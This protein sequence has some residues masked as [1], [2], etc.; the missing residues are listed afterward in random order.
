MAKQNQSSSSWKQFLR[1]KMKPIGSKVQSVEKTTLR[2]AKRFV[3]SRL[4]NVRSVR[5]HVLGWLVMIFILIGLAALQ[6]LFYEK[7]ATHEVS[8][9]GGTYAEGMIDT[10]TTLNP[11]FASTAVEKSLS[12][13]LFVGLES[14]DRKGNLQNE[15]ADSVIIS[16]KDKLY[17]VT[18]RPNLKWHDGKTL[19]SQ[20][21]AFTVGLM[22]NPKTGYRDAASW[23]NVQV[24]A[25]DDQTIVFRLKGPYAPFMSSLTFPILPKHIL[26]SVK[27]ELLQEHSFSH[28]PIG[29]GPFEY[30]G[31]QVINI[32][33]GKS[34]VKLTAFKDYWNGQP[35]LSN[36]IVYT[37]GSKA[38]ALK[39]LRSHEVSAVSD[40]YIKNRQRF[41]DRGY[42]VT[43]ISIDS[44]VYALL[45]LSRPLLQDAS[46]R[47]ALVASTNRTVFEKDMN[48]QQLNAPLIT[49]YLPE[50]SKH[51][52]AAY[53][54]KTAEQFFS[55]AGWK[56]TDNKLTKDGKP[57]ELTIT[58]IDKPRYRQAAD[59]LAKQWRNAGIK[60]TTQ[61]VDPDQI[62]QS[63][64][65]PRSYDV[66]I[67][68]LEIG[69]DPDVTAY[70]HS[71]GRT[72][73]GLNLSEYSSGIVDDALTAARLR[74]DMSV[75]DSKYTT[76]VKEW[77]KDVPAIALY[78]PTLNYV[79]NQNIHSF[80]SSDVLPSQSDRFD[81]A[82]YW[83]VGDRVVY[84]TP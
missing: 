14:Y 15:L 18:L 54:T 5:R 65:K 17:T 1:P 51:R 44:G 76:F 22:Q 3:I 27:P 7:N 56:K 81:S 19:T 46:L 49:D 72:G 28:S 26:K 11:L 10:F 67:Y 83:S 41:I 39:G 31:T 62:Q 36:L 74:G 79:S 40:V 32:N 59:L 35:S 57:L 20:D 42:D 55:Q 60:V 21:V 37:Y 70:W 52:Q 16:E 64:L 30:D 2:H 77:L 58:S 43:N 33:N 24:S 13:A 6:M 25:K 84:R 69:A 82:Q 12:S 63:T 8:E 23:Q 73:N 9:S 48:G 45:N 75:R 29:S 61:Y 71:S 68:E 80:E 66:L 53:D 34:A 4:E 38:D 47:K 78:R 50:S